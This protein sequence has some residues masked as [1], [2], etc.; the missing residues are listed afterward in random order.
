MPPLSVTKQDNTG[1]APLT[2]GTSPP[3]P[4]GDRNRA[5]FPIMDR[6]SRNSFL[7]SY[8]IQVSSGMSTVIAA[9]CVVS[10]SI[11]SKYSVLLMRNHRS[12]PAG[13]R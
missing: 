10:V 12:D 5:L 13:K 7:K 4:A 3:S 6:S 8:R 11:D 2:V 1:N 9:C